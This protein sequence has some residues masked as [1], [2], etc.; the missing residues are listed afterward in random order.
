MTP[1]TTND[2]VPVT[3]NNNNGGAQVKEEAANAAVDSLANGDF[4]EF[5]DSGTSTYIYICDTC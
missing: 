3:N 2:G 1:A 4:D 5:P